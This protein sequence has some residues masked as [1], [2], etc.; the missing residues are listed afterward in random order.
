MERVRKRMESVRR[1]LLAMGT[2]LLVVV[3]R[4]SGSHPWDRIGDWMCPFGWERERMGERET[5]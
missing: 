4:G 2:F 1:G 3:F 5:Y